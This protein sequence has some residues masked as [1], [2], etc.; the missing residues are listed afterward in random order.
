MAVTVEQTK[1][2]EVV[3][4]LRKFVL[5]GRHRAAWLTLEEQLELA[6]GMEIAERVLSALDPTWGA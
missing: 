4:D 5:E 3:R 1:V 6:G 2:D